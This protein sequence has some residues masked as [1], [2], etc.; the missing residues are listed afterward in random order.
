VESELKSFGTVVRIAVDTPVQ[1]SV[2]FAT[3]KDEKTKFGWG[4][5]NPGHGVSFISMKTPELAI[6][7]APC[8]ALETRKSIYAKQLVSRAGCFLFLKLVVLI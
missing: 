3:Y 4:L 6:A 7:A 1:Q 8:R 2:S 5:N